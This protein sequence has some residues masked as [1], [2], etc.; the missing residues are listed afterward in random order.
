MTGQIVM[1]AY[2]ADSNYQAQPLAGPEAKA[3]QP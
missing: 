3:S 2:E 1:Q